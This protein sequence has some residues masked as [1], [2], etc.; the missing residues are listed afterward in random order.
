M[1]KQAR[2]VVTLVMLLVLLTLLATAAG[3]A[4]STA[5]PDD[6]SQSTTGPVPPPGV[7]PK[8]ERSFEPGRT[9]V[10]IPGVP[11]YLWRHGCGPTAVGMVIGYYDCSGYDDLIP[12]FSFTQTTEVDNAIASEGSP[13][14]PAH[15]EDYSEP[16]DDA[17]TGILPDM[18]EPPAGDEHDDDCIADFMRTSW[19]AVNN[20][21]GWSYGADIDDA[22][23]DYIAHV[24]PSY[25]PV[26]TKHDMLAGEF[27]WDDL[28][29]EIDA[30][31]PMVFLVDTVGDGAT[32]HFV[33]V[34]GY[35]DDTI[36]EYACLDTWYPADVLRWCEFAPMGGGQ[37]WGVDS[38]WSFKP[39]QV[40]T[41]GT[42]VPADFTEIQAAI[43]A[44][45]GSGRVLVHPGTYTGAGN[46][47]LDFG[48]KAVVLE[49]LAGADS[50]IIDCEGLGRG[51]N[52][53]SGETPDSV[54]DGFTIKDGAAAMGGGVR[55]FWNSS[56]TL[57]NLFLDGC[58]ATGDG[59]GLWVAA[60]S[61]PHISGV[62][63]TSCSAARG[64][65]MHCNAGRPTLDGVTMWGNSATN[66]S[67]VSCAVNAS[68]DVVRTIIAGGTGGG[69]VYC[70]GADSP[71]FSR[72]CV[73]GSAGG[74]SLCGSYSENLFVDPVFCDEFAG[75]FSLRSDSPCLPE[76]NP[77]GDLIGAHGMGTCEVGVGGSEEWTSLA[78]RPVSPNPA[79]NVARITFDLQQ[80][81]EVSIRVYDL[82]GRLVRDLVP[83]RRFSGGPQTVLWDGRD[84]D[85]APVASGVYFCRAV[86][87]AGAGSVRVVVL[88]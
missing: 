28:V 4:R 21:Y 75:D 12:G 53:D 86:S 65:A 30:E 83:P 11:A 45:V 5:L 49:S 48:G 42:Q 7:A 67:G 1:L 87:E 34:V 74:D 72:C 16:E 58:V 66:G 61:E 15:Y 19:S 26:A 10:T 88:R 46:R 3:A 56:P 44:I 81:T 77:W 20:Y 32:D 80:P 59:G 41:V 33:T 31:R 57:R 14:E 84:G 82:R 9:V 13:T 29:A 38:A 17:G 85:G 39:D 25:N 63:V 18:S 47:D 23:M 64:G 71:S 55:C 69:A 78:I 8:V 54:V 2:P 79:S 60:G 40:Y 27:S 36:Q 43:D 52:F 68:P 76:N 70:D 37:L 22:F 62:T 73:H 51:L 35:S 6:R 24:N 50:T